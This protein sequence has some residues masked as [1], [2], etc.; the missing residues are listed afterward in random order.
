MNGCINKQ[1]ASISRM[2]AAHMEAPWHTVTGMNEG[3]ASYPSAPTKRT[4]IKGKESTLICIHL[5]IFYTK[6]ARK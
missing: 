3:F 4:P 2:A 5:L 6:I 1:Y